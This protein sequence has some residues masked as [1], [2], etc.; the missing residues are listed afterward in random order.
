MNE[1]K[2]SDSRSERKVNNRGEENFWQRK[3][4]EKF[5]DWCF[6]GSVNK[7]EKKK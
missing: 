4:G 1:V 6:G 7:S 2:L 3:V 5:F